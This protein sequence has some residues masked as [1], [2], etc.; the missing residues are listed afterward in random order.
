MVDGQ[1]DFQET[2]QKF[3]MWLLEQGLCND[4]SAFV[5]SGDWDLQVLLPTQCYNEHLPVPSYFTSW[6]NI[7]QVGS[8]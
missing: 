1:C 4:K 7:K 5:T 8:V 6:I 2:L 3:D